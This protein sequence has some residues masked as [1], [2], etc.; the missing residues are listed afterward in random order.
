M[1]NL[2][3]GCDFSAE[4]LG[5][6]TH[7]AAIYKEGKTAHKITDVY[8]S[9]GEAN[10]FGSIRKYGRE[11]MVESSVFAD[12]LRYLR[13]QFGIKINLAFNS[14][15]PH[16][17]H[18]WLSTN[19]FR[20]PDVS[21]AIVEYVHKWGALVDYWI[22]ASPLLVELFH[23]HREYLNN[24]QISIST[25]MNVHSLP[26]VKWVAEHWPLVSKICPA[27][28]RNR[29]YSWLK[30]GNALV[31]FELLANEFC[32]IDGVECEGL[33]R[34][35]CYL[36]QA[37]EA[38]HWN[39]METC[40]IASRER[41]PW[42]W[43]QARYILPQ[44]INFYKDTTGVNRYKIT[45]RTHKADYITKIGKAYVDGEFDGNL[46]EL[47]GQLQAMLH[48]ENW[49]QEQEKAEQQ[50]YIPVS[51]IPHPQIHY[52]NCG[53]D[54]CGVY[55]HRCEQL[56]LEMKKELDM[57]NPNS[58]S[59]EPEK[60]ETESEESAADP[61]DQQDDE[62]EDLEDATDDAGDDGAKAENVE[63]STGA[64]EVDDKKESSSAT[65][66]TK[67]ESESEES[68]GSGDV[69]SSDQ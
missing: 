62:V 10:P 18:G 38:A 12:R 55:C 14:V 4:H 45:G 40:C 46:L 53:V 20:N 63:A 22:L 29:D 42:S 27:L 19:C 35:A 33:Y 32:S 1:A 59:G 17:K 34:Q 56:Y 28:W 31:P 16:K 57:P 37:V 67:E 2:N 36:S 11:T 64:A 43:L 68:Q 41:T 5:V 23:K 26:Q 44:W 15:L 60:E 51:M 7:L 58:G 21:K 9:P 48:K 24:P 6:I 65:E 8:G 61:E 3:M 69:E 47:W 52:P 66:K 54:D 39:P 13:E 30:R 50:V 49:E 25:I